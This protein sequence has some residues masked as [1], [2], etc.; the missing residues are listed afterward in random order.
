MRV[1]QP[2][3]MEADRE[4]IEAASESRITLEMSGLSTE[5]CPMPGCSD[6]TPDEGKL[7]GAP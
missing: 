3:L 6:Q 7:L 2:V 4:D 5:N 1:L